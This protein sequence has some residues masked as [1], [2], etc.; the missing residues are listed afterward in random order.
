MGDRG[1]R[2]MLGGEKAIMRF[3]EDMSVSWYRDG[4]AGE[5]GLRT[6][7]EAKSSVGK[8]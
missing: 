5:G 1:K 7:K 4:K 2:V 8:N 3:Y 6:V